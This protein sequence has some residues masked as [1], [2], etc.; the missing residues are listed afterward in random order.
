MSG[1][2]ETTSIN[3]MVL[4]NRF[5]RS[6]TIMGMA[7]IDG[8]YTTHLIDKMK[9]LAEGGVGL[10]ITGFAYV[11]R[12][13]K[14]NKW[15]LGCY[16]DELMPG[17]TQMA[18]AVHTCG[19]RI[20]LQIVHCGLF[21][22]PELTG[23]PAPG[24]SVRQSENGPM[25]VEMTKDDIQEAVAAYRSAA[26]RGKKAGFDAVQVHAAHGYQLGQFLSPYLNKRTDE[27]GGSLVNRARMFLEAVT[28]V[29][30]TVGSDYPVLVKIN[31]EDRLDGGFTIDEMVKVSLMLQDIDVDAIEMSGGTA[32]GFALNK[33]DL[34]PSRV[35]KNEVVYWQNAAKKYKSSVD[36]PLILVGG[37]RSFETAE[38]LVKEGTTDYISLSRPLIR[39][40]GLINRWKNGDRRP[41]ECISDN[42][43][44]GP[45][46]KGEG[47]RCIHLN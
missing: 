32:L 47:V 41:A 17:L 29:R 40:P 13:G 21:S 31:A 43:C 30:K 7:E 11:M 15:Q 34:S 35:G 38:N 4:P 22:N 18:D 44:F 26:E 39:E 5:V 25:G 1:L 3:G 36:V 24:P 45:I 6:A 28:E 10:I 19:G 14:S 23:E 46:M 42:G 12:N 2:F 33:P 16:G 8:S 27:Y 9:N 20:A 37:I